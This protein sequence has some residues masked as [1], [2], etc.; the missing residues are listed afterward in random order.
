MLYVPL[1]DTSNK[2]TW[3]FVYRSGTKA[4]VMLLCSHGD[5]IHTLHR[6]RINIPRVCHVPP[7]RRG[8]MSRV[9][10]YRLLVAAMLQR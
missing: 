9:V 7:L 8:T 4:K 3:H 1:L 5:G 2:G 10:Y 6:L